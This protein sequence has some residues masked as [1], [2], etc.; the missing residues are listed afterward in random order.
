[1]KAQLGF[2]VSLASLSLAVA[3][4]PFTAGDLVVLQ[5]GTGSAAPN[6]AATALFVNEYSL[7]P[8]T[9]VQQITVPADGT[10]LTLSGSASSEGSLTLS[11]DGTMVTFGGYVASAGTAGIASSGVPRAVGVISPQGTFSVT[12]STVGSLAFASNNVRTAV[13]DG[14][15]YWMGGTAAA[16]ANGGV[17]YSTGSGAPTQ[18]TS[19]NFRNLNLSGGNLLYSTGSGTHGIYQFTGAP[20]GTASAGSAL[21]PT[22]SSSSP[23]DFAISADGN[24]AYVADDGSTTEGVQKWIKSGGTWSLAYTLPVG[25]T[26]GAR[27]LTV[28]WGNSL[29]FATTG[30]TTANR[31]IE[32]FD[33]GS[34]A[35]ST[36]TTLDTAAANTVFRGVDFAPVPEPSTV[37]L[38]G[39]GL[40]AFFTRRNRSA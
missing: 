8:N 25:S 3:Q 21:I 38:L 22:G 15:G 2:I 19:G 4:T 36:E 10:G 12:A 6:S 14:H 11:S 32:I 34:L 17:W 37:A 27:Q 28:D 39:L 9:L 40:V 1:M 16:S 24:T 7:T 29:I 33:G 31:L 30:E 5:V 20:T 26:S 18:V 35:A 13:S 23:Y